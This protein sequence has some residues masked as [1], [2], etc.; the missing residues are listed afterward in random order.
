M[1]TGL[2]GADVQQLRDLANQFDRGAQDLQSAAAT[3]T[4]GVQAQF[5]M[6]HVALRFKTTWETQHSVR[7]KNAA[8][9]MK[10]GA[11]A[12]RRDADE[13]DRASR[14]DVGGGGSGSGTV[15]PAGST[16]SGESPV[17]S[18]VDNVLLK[19]MDFGGA[20]TTAVRLLLKKGVLKNLLRVPSGGLKAF[21]SLTRIYE[22]AQS[23]DGTE[24]MF[25]VSNLIGGVS[26]ILSV[27]C[28]PLFLVGLASGAMNFLVNHPD[29]AAAIGNVVGDAIHGVKN[30]VVDFAN[31]AKEVAK[32]FYNEVKTKVV[33]GGKY[34]VEKAKQAVTAAVDTGKKVIDKGVDFVKKAGNGI[35]DAWNYL[36][37]KG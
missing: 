22:A 13:Q 12:L 26:T 19:A 32:S 6:G 27:A 34:V 1:A 31:S 18:F 25:Q 23:G 29:V 11:E 10:D 36:F 7:L 5:W 14:G 20:A 8:Q 9:A 17:R 30:A 35:K 3:V 28:P 33:E 16:S 15:K 2:V 4:R 37:G 21:T 24:F